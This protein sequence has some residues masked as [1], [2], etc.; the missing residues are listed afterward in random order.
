M[1]GVRMLRVLHALCRLESQT[2][3][4]GGRRRPSASRRERLR[5]RRSRSGA[6]GGGCAAS[7]PPL[8]RSLAQRPPPASPEPLLRDQNDEPE[9]A[10]LGST[11]RRCANATKACA[12]ATSGGNGCCCCAPLSAPA[13]DSRARRLRLLPLR[14]DDVASDERGSGSEGAVDASSDQL[15][16][17]EDRVPLGA[18]ATA[19]AGGA[20][21]GRPR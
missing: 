1:H 3:S 18:D 11:G 19:T 9:G 13:G 16:E 5:L 6:G 12:S 14:R 4:S 20:A 15:E 2:R 21:S 8:P 17:P 10:G 7:A